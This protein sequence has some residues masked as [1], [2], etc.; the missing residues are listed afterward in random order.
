MN[1][2]V[3]WQD[4]RGG[5]GYDIYG[6]QVASNGMVLATNDISIATSANG[7]YT[8]AVSHNGENFL[9]VWQDYRSGYSRIFGARVS[10]AGEPLD[11]SGI[12]IST[13][14]APQYS[15]KI[16]YG[17]TNF[18]VVW[19]DY[20][21]GYTDI[22]GARVS[23]SG[24]VL[25]TG[26]IPIS[27]ANSWQ[28]D[29]AVA[30]N[31]VDFLVVWE[32]YRSGTSYDIYGA[33]VSTSGTVLDTG[34]IPISSATNGQYTPAVSHNG[35]NF[36]VVWE[37]Y[38]SGTSYDIYGA[39]VSSDGSVL[40]SSGIAISSASSSQ[41]TPSVT[42]NGVDFLVVWQ[43]SRSGSAD[44][45]GTRVSGGGAVLDSSGIAISTASNTQ[46]SP[47]V[48]YNGATFL[49]VWQDFRS[50]TGFSDIYGARV[51]ET[52]S[53]LEN[54]GFAISAEPGAEVQPKVT[55]MG[56]ES[57]LVVYRGSHASTTTN[58][59]RVLARRVEPSPP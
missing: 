18:L 25:D 29:P 38:R 6:A 32:D 34:G 54:S 45:Y 39:R 16:A 24:M 14:S 12:S 55:S 26:G 57:S 15:P 17:E 35:E 27:T 7:Q 20:R 36:L 41:S 28:E 48:G 1:F 11:P 47:S 37:D 52:G 43:D 10:E 5:T 31:G 42:H 2:L 56:G 4:Y 44:I 33:R 40:D 50:G 59:E 21:N 22:Y 30:Y 49:V 58:S 8:P 23:S 13:A 9:I 51:S 46:A 53:V 3:V 19:H